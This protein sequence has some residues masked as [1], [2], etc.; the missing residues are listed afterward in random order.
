MTLEDQVVDFILEKAK[1]TEK[2]VTFEEMMN[3]Q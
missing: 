1:V 2:P 3:N